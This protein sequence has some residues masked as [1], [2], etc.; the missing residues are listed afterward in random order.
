MGG[1]FVASASYLALHVRI[2][3]EGPPFNCTPNTNGVFLRQKTSS[4][5]PLPCSKEFKLAR[6]MYLY[7]IKGRSFF[8][9]ISIANNLSLRH[10]S[11]QHSCKPIM[12]PAVGASVKSLPPCPSCHALAIAYT[13]CASIVHGRNGRSNKFG[14]CAIWIFD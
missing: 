8:N 12:C 14:W 1:L 10:E 9:E 2:P 11:L 7:Q 4:T 5:V 13:W 3:Y 6:N